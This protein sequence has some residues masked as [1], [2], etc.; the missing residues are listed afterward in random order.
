MRIR[1]PGELFRLA[2]LILVLSLILVYLAAL[3]GFT[4]SAETPFP[5]AEFARYLFFWVALAGVALAYLLF[6]FFRAY[7]RH[8][9]RQ[10]LFLRVLIL[11][12]SHRFGNFL[13][14][15]K[16]KLSLAE[17]RPEALSELRESLSL[18]EKDLARLLK[19]LRYFLEEGPAAYEEPPREVAE[20]VLKR[21]EADWGRRKIRLRLERLPNFLRSPEGELLLYLLLENA[22]RHGGEWIYLRAG[23]FRG[24]VYLALGND[25]RPSPSPGSGLGLY[26]SR[27]LSEHL[28]L[29]LRIESR[30]NRF[31]VLLS[32]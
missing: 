3:L 7:E 2:L 1:T 22:Y 18:M 12:L 24:R 8:A 13:S 23:R 16:V 14:A 21:L 15:Q 4:V 31:W 20:R 26:L 32:A 9:R 10:E 11:S 19:L 29:R 17:S 28:G 30:R 25:C 5:P 27:R 6:V